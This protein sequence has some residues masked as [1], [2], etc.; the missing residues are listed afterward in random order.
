MSITPE[1]LIYRFTLPLWNQRTLSVVDTCV[2]PNATIQTTLNS[3]IGPSVLK[4]AAKQTFAAFSDLHLS[5][6]EQKYHENGVILAWSGQ[7]L[8]TGPLLATLPTHTTIQ[9]SGITS[10]TLR[11]GQIC[12]FKSFSD[13]P[14]TLQQAQDNSFN[15]ERTITNLRAATGKKMTRREIECLQLWIKGFSIKESA[16]ALGGLSNRTIQT[17]RENIKRKLNVSTYHKLLS[18]IQETGL[19][20]AFLNL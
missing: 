3:G 19:L 16:S 6:T 5:I 9:F 4:E 15:I 7:A 17:F 10:H 13:L 12:D 2:D 1:D 11:A 14:R 20:P 18:L 8:H